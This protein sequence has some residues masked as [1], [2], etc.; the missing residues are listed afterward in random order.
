MNEHLSP[1]QSEIIKRQFPSSRF[2]YNDT[3]DLDTLHL[4][5]QESLEFEG[6]THFS[7]PRY[8]LDE[9]A[10]V[11]E[12]T[13]LNDDAR[14]L[15]PLIPIQGGP[16]CLYRTQ[17]A[18]NPFFKSLGLSHRTFQ[19]SFCDLG[20]EQYSKA[21]THVRSVTGFAVKQ[22]V[23]AHRDNPDGKG[24]QSFNVTGIL[25]WH[26]MEAFF[27]KIIEAALPPSLFY[28]S[29]R[30]DE[31]IR[32]GDTLDTL[33]PALQ[34]AGHGIRLFSTG[35]ENFSPDENR[36]LNKSIENQQVE[37]ATERILGWC[38]K[39]PETFQF[40]RRD[41]YSFILFTPWTRLSDLNI[42]IREIEKNPLINRNYVMGT[43]L[44][45]FRGRPITLLAER[46]GL[47]VEALDD[48]YYNAGCIVSWDNDELP[49]RFLSPQ[50]GLLFR[51]A[52][53]LSR[54]GQV[55]LDDGERHLVTAF[56]QSLPGAL[57]DDF[58]LFKLFVTVV[59]KDSRLK[60]VEEVLRQS[61]HK[62]LNRQALDRQDQT[63][64]LDQELAER[65]YRY[66]IRYKER[67]PELLGN[68]VFQSMGFL[69]V[70]TLN[71][72]RMRFMGPEQEL[73]YLFLQPRRFQGGRSL[74]S[75]HFALWHLHPAPLDAP[76]KRVLMK[77]LPKLVE[78][79][80]RR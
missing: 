12:R 69:Q 41:G 16:S 9:I 43:R 67:Q 17:V 29:P 30:I 76:W 62:H 21:L 44:Q 45:L 19:C 63:A 56:K 55:P 25:L 77:L 59:E 11:Y 1:Q 15:A 80:Y 47:L 31:L 54:Q 57:Q 13:L 71:T 14:S 52:R 50:V 22:V 34:R 24:R 46:D 2:L 51:L 28:F 33:L 78:K 72:L 40:P 70:P 60:S 61:A 27:L 7:E 75:E 36:R 58:E 6:L 79:A 23:N 4:F 48:H 35:I 8:Y 5:F 42:N 3:D 65:I 39:F 26:Q 10:P 73:L 18:K 49:W 20:Q 38:G 32:L 66:F 74:F 64:R 37:E 68:V 53:R